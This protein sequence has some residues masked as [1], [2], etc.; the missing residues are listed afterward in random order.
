MSLD[1]LVK[2]AWKGVDLDALVRSQ[3]AHFKDLLCTRIALG[4]PQLSV[5]ATAA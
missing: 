1:L 2:S 3:L 4:G 5:S